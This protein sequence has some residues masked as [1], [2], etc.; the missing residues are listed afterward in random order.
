MPPLLIRVLGILSFIWLTGCQAPLQA[1]PATVPMH[2][3]LMLAAG[4][5]VET[6]L[7]AYTAASIDHVRLTLYADVAG[8]YVPTGAATSV[9]VTNLASAVNLGDLKMNTSYRIEADAYSSPTESATTLISVPASSTTNFVT[10]AIAASGG[11]DTLDD[12]AIAL[13]PV[14]L[15]LANQTYAGA[16]TFQVNLSTAMKKKCST[17]SVTLLAG[18]TQ[19]FQKSYPVAQVGQIVTITN[20]KDATSYVLRA[21]GYNAK[22]QLQSNAS[23]STFSFTTPSVTSGQIDTTVNTTAYAVPCQ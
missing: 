6:V 21:D 23:K 19:V 4:Y 22:G 8:R 9:S 10:P 13:V 11:V 14:G 5:R 16:A 2:A 12:S 3:R 18:S 17:V 1:P 7:T 15:T 20:L